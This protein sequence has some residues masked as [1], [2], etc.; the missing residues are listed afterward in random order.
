MVLGPLSK[1]NKSSRHIKA[2]EAEKD[3]RDE[4]EN[5]N[6]MQELVFSYLKSTCQVLS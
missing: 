1:H 3:S 2:V 5:A 4:E 6:I